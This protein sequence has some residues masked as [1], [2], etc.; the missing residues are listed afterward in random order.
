M[1]NDNRGLSAA[2]AF[3]CSALALLSADAGAQS[4]APSSAE[5]RKTVR[6]VRIATPPVIDGKLDEAVWQ[7]ADVITD[8]HQIR[9]G[10]GATPSEPTEVYVLYDDDAFYIGAR[11]HDSEPDSIAAPTIRHGQGLG[12]DDRL[13]VILD[14]FNTRRS[15]YRFE[16]NP[17]G[18]RHD[19]LYQSINSFQSDWTVIWDT[20]ATIDETG[21]IAEMAIPFKSLPFDPSNGLGFQ[22][23]ARHPPARRGDGVGVV[24]PHLQPEHLGRS[25]RHAGHGPGRRVGR[26]AVARGW[27]AKAFV[28]GSGVDTTDWSRT[29][30]G[31]LLSV[32]AV[33][34]RRAHD[35]HG[36][37]RD[38]SRQPPSQPHPLQSVFSRK[39]DFFLND[40]DLF[41]FGHSGSGPMK[42]RRRRGRAARMRGRF[43]RAASA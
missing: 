21:W 6:M 41:Q 4:A 25:H 7:T 9:P 8:F 38:R 26:R 5:A 30:A 24:Q 23:R 17:N 1:A 11:M 33:A 36:F 39:R 10:D 37:L 12:R 29:L 22:L 40:A 20:A 3:A 13:V 34:E 31:R 43:F 2:V 14:P 28:S 35:Q 16:T 32:D 42:T 18:V 15:G 27:P 19:A